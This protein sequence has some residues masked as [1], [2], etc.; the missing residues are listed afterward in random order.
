MLEKKYK[1]ISRIT[2]QKL[3]VVRN[4]Y[5]LSALIE[6]GISV[7][8]CLYDY[9]VQAKYRGFKD[10]IDILDKKGYSKLIDDMTIKRTV[11]IA[12][13]SASR[14]KQ[15]NYLISGVIIRYCSYFYDVSVDDMIEDYVFRR[16]FKLK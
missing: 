15:L 14:N 1:N 10:I 7:T 16:I 5:A 9:Y 8:K 13:I 12:I 3:I 6:N 11:L 4:S 2:F